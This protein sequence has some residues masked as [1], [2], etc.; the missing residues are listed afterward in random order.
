[1]VWLIVG[2]VILAAASCLQ[3]IASR[4]SRRDVAS[5]HPSYDS[6]ADITGLWDRRQLDELLGP[7]DENDRYTATAADIDRIPRTW[8]KQLFDSDAADYVCLLLA[9]V[10]PLVY[11]SSSEVAIALFAVPALYTLLGYQGAVSMV[12]GSERQR[13]EPGESQQAD[14]THESRSL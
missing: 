12:L 4:E 8:W 7:R 6:V 14:E 10:A 5:G 1:M 3:L 2:C 13:S 9:I 11:R